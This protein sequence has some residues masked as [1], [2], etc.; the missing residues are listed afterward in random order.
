MQVMRPGHQ[1]PDPDARGGDNQMRE[2]LPAMIA[3][4]DIRL[5]QSERTGKEAN[6]STSETDETTA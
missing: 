6:L 1:G 3:P 4:L 2:K 5:Q